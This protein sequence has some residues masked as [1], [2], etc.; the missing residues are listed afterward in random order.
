MVVKNLNMASPNTPCLGGVVGKVSV[1]TSNGS[2]VAKALIQNG[3]AQQA[4]SNIG[5]GIDN[6]EAPTTTMGDCKL[7]CGICGKAA[8]GTTALTFTSAA[9]T[10]EALSTWTTYESGENAFESGSVFFVSLPCGNGRRG[11]G[12]GRGCPLFSLP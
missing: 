9:G 11:C 5:V 10:A 8:S 4:D 3:Y 1:N 6:T 7:A 12:R 2:T